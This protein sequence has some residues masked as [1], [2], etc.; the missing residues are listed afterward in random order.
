MQSYNWLDEA[1]VKQLNAELVTEYGGP[2]AQVRDANLL[3]S[4]LSRPQNLLAYSGAEPSIHAPTA[5][6]GF[7]LARNHPFVDGNKR[8]ALMAMYVFVEDNGHM[9]AAPEAE[10]AAMIEALAAGDCDEA[11]LIAWLRE[12]VPPRSLR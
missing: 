7:G 9:F 6:Y 10:A 3:G 1:A 5:A 4:A 11:G 12:H 2:D 8:T